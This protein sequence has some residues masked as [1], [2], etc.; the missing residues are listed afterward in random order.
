MVLIKDVSLPNPNT[1][2]HM[3]I[4]VR[5]LKNEL[6]IKVFEKKLLEILIFTLL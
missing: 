6:Q 1:Y 4:P 5:T 2:H 3:T